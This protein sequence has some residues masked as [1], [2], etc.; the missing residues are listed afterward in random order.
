MTASCKTGDMCGLVWSGG[1]VMKMK[2]G[3]EQAGAGQAWPGLAWPGL[4]GAAGLE[5]AET[6]GVVV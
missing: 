5:E 2:G 3:R 6:G 4:C 1:E